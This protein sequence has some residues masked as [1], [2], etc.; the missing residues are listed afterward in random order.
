MRE[1]KFR[2][3]IKNL[4]LLVPVL[5]IN[6]DIKTVEVDLTSCNGD[7]V[8]YNF[9]EIELMQYTGINDT[10]GKEICAGD[11]I[12]FVW[13]TDSCWGD[14]GTYMGYVQHDDGAYE[15]VYINRQEYTP[16][17][18]GYKHPNSESD[19]LQSFIR[20]TDGV[21]CEV[22]GNIYENPELLK[23]IE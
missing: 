12:E 11:I 2:A 21:N 14:E 13:E 23:V 22:I 16:T 10:N 18:D 6:F 3:Y 19:E 15:V 9:D 4:K 8:E 5:R 1:I 17:K 20:W 7:L